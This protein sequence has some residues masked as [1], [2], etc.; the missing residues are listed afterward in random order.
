ME[1]L[2]IGLRKVFSRELFEECLQ[3][4]TYVNIGRECNFSGK[5]LVE[6]ILVNARFPEM[7]PLAT[8]GESYKPLP[9]PPPSEIHLLQVRIR[10]KDDGF[11]FGP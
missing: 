9:F 4:R 5:S 10:H 11:G 7:Q 6:K 2:G 1:V 8:K 3:L